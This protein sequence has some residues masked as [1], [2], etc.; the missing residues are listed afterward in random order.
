MGKHFCLDMHRCYFI[1]E[2]V[3]KTHYANKYKK[4]VLKVYSLYFKFIRIDLLPIC[5][6]TYVDDCKFS[7]T[8]PMKGLGGLNSFPPVISIGKL[9]I[10][11]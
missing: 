4:P 3:Y 10:I 6:W 5:T 9:I 2:T 7:S 8:L 1:K 11:I